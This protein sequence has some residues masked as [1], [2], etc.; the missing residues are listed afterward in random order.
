MPQ[1]TARQKRVLLILLGTAGLI[2]I[3]IAAG[4]TRLEL[5]PGLPLP[6]IQNGGALVIES[7]QHSLPVFISFREF[8]LLVLK[9]VVGCNLVY[10][11][12]RLIKG[13]SWH[14]VGKVLLNGL[15][16]MASIGG[17]IILT[18]LLLPRGTFEPSL[19]IPILELEPV[20]RSPLEPAPRILLW[21]VGILLAGICVLVVVWIFNSLKRKR[22]PIDLVQLDAEKAYQELLSGRDFRDVIVKCYRQM[23]KALEYE[24]AIE[25]KS[26]MTTGEFERLL[27]DEGFPFEP[28]HQLTHLFEVVR[29]GHERPSRQEEQNAIDCLAAIVNHCREFKKAV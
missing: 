5:Q 22:K 24:R 29:Y 6:N 2:M 16:I 21:V 15:I 17:V 4:L 25:R 19:N 8:F 23:S 10:F 14:E 1:M 7:D 11:L 13:I 9:F 12:Y 26:N 3:L 18:M 20:E 27:I 28:V